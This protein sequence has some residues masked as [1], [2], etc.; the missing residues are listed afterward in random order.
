MIYSKSTLISTGK[1]N[2]ILYSQI[3]AETYVVCDYLDHVEAKLIL[4]SMCDFFKVCT[5]NDEGGYL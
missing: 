4:K 5:I 1:Y 3:D 2:I